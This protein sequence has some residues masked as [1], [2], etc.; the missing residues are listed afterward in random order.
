MDKITTIVNHDTAKELSKRTQ[1]LVLVG[2]VF[3]FV[4]IGLYV[5]FGFTMNSWGE[6]INIILLVLGCF[7]IALSGMLEMGVIKRVNIYKKN[8]YEATYEFFDKYFVLQAFRNGEKYQEEKVKYE[9][10]FGYFETKNYVI[11]KLNTWDAIPLTKVEG[12]TEFLDSK[13]VIRRRK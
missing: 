8:G 6:I 2:I 1:L 4:C 9:N 10:I 3:G 7:L 12:L 13:G 5:L 11:L